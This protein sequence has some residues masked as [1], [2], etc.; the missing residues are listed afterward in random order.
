MKTYDIGIIGGGVAGA[1]AALRIAQLHRNVKTILIEFGRP[2]GKRR[3]QLEGWLGCLPTGDGKIYP[4][5]VAKI[6]DL[7][8]GR[9]V[10]AINRWFFN[11]LNEVN[12][13][14]LVRTR[15]P[16]AATLRKIKTAGFEVTNRHYF[17]WRPESIHQLSRLIA[18][19]VE[20]GNVAFSFDN[21]VYSFARSN[22]QFFLST[23]E[24][25]IKC[26]RLILCAGRS[27]WR[28]VNEMYRK[29]GILV[30]DDIA[31]FGIRVELPAQYLKDF[32]Q[33]HCTWAREGLQIGPMQWGG[34][35]IQE[36]HAD[37]TTA[38][39]RSNEDRWKSDKTFF[40]II[41]HREF[42]GKGCFQSSRLAQ[43][44]FLLSGDRV[45]R[46]KIRSFMKRQD[47]LSLVPEF[48]WLRDVIDELTTIIPPLISRGYYHCPDIQTCTPNLRIGANL[49]S[50]V[51][52]LFVAGESAGITGI[53]A[54]AISGGL[55][56]ESATK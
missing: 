55:A 14:K 31:R 47:Q 3:R 46:E 23:A 15:M 36:D 25:D 34:S 28:W 24:G 41:G 16:A 52:G 4:S 38:A 19:R 39:Y 22:G 26:K 11:H 51:R 33:S 35:I 43:L 1:F 45:G 44:A 49:E 18:E 32:N 42:E 56:A 53:A 12:P 40:S 30:N 54:A 50:E 9:R 2:P 29:L 7:A 37:M 13:C 20:G 8:D 27:G 21:E 5:D 6:L 17:Q 48:A 10:K